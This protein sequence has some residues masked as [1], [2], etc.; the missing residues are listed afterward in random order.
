MARGFYQVRF[1]GVASDTL[2]AAFDD[3]EVE[4][5]EGATTLR[6]A[7]EALLGVIDRLQDLGL[8]LLDVGSEVGTA[9]D[10]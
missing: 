1:K 9:P 6:C 4:T 5:A 3:C 8:E 7:Q 10:G 2:R